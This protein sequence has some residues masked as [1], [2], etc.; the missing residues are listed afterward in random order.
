MSDSSSDTRW[1]SVSAACEYLDVSKTTLYEYMKDGRLPYY[2]LAGTRQR[3]VK[4]ADLDALLV[5]G[6][7]EDDRDSQD[8]N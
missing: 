5:R 3:R 4:Q 8:K 7:P 2:Y 1:Y 6:N